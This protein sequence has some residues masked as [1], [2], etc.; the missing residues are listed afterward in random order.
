MELALFV[1]VSSFIGSLGNVL[2]VVGIVASALSLL[3]WG[4]RY[5]SYADDASSSYRRG[6]AVKP[7]SKPFLVVIVIGVVI[8]LFATLLPSQKT[9]YLIAGAWAGQKVVQSETADKVLRIVNSK[10]DEYLV[11]VEKSVKEGAK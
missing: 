5:A 2:M 11:D 9:M 6:D 1:W 3:V 7:H 8:T 10:L 4:V